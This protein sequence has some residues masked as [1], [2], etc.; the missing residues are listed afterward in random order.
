MTVHSRGKRREPFV[1]SSI[2]VDDGG[3]RYR[4]VVVLFTD[5]VIRKSHNFILIRNFGVFI[6]ISM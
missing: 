5:H 3:N 4:E 6:Y 2:V 1:F